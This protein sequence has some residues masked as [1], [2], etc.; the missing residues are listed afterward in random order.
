MSEKQQ[1]IKKIIWISHLYL[2]LKI[3]IKVLYKVI[4][5]YNNKSL[6]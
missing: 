6:L 3:I 5:Y 2:L 1:N 4:N